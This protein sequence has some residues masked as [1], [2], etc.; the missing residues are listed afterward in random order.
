MGLFCN[1][2]LPYKLLFKML[3]CYILPILRYCSLRVNFVLSKNF[4]TKTEA[5][6]MCFLKWTMKIIW[7]AKVRN[8]DVLRVTKHKRFLHG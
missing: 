1:Q 2:K 8:Q 4:E 3:N 5:K 7:T 6:E